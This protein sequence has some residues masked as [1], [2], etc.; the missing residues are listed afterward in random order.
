MK[1]VDPIAAQLPGIL[2]A[3]PQDTP[4]V[5]VNLLKFREQASYKHDEAPCSG[6]EAYGRYSEVAIKMVAK[7][8]GKPIYMGKVKGLPIAPPEEQWDE[9]L[10]VQYPSAQAFATMLA[11]LDYRAITKHRTA[12]LED[13]RLIATTQMGAS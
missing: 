4:I 9:V 8:G 7:V 3:L 10:L 12:A 6:K 13:A 2:A 11:D 1:T 5:M